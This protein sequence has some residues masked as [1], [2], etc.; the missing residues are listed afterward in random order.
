[1]DSMPR[2]QHV[3]R[4]IK[5]ELS[6]KSPTS[7]PH[8]PMTSNILLKLRSVWEEDPTAFDNVMLWAACCMCYFGFLWSGE[9]C[10]PSDTDYDQCIHLSFSDITIDSHET[11]SAI[12]VR[13]KASRNGP[14]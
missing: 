13:I 3:L 9:I 4:G 12:S 14:L 11:P 5:R 6:K 7:K 10:T 8:L 1:M 2:L